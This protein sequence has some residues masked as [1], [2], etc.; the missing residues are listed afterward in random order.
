MDATFWNNR[1]EDNNIPWDAG[2]IT[3]PLKAYIDQLKDKA[4]RILIP[5]CGN[6]HEAEYLLQEGFTQVYVC[7]WATEALANFKK[8]VPDFPSSHLIQADFFKL[9]NQFD[10]IL[11][12]TFLSALFPAQREAYAKQ[13]YRL[14]SPGG[15][16]IGVLFNEGTEDSPPFGGTA[17]EFLAIFNPVFDQVKVEDCYNSIKPRQGRELFIR[18]G[19]S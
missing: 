18:L 1:Y 19:K 9:E 10:L 2:R 13:M 3:T 6:A 4:I 14:V 15:K 7:D 16:V 5:G 11:E 12:Q 8:R 17:E